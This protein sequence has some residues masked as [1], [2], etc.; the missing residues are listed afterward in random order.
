MHV[1]GCVKGAVGVDPGRPG[2][3]DLDRIQVDLDVEA[4][5]STGSGF[6]GLA[7]LRVGVNQGQVLK[8]VFRGRNDPNPIPKQ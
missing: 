6:D 4:S 5:R 3:D 8:N 1:S 7:L 2:L